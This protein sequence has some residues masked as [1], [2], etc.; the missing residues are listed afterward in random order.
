MTVGFPGKATSITDRVLSSVDVV[1]GS[2]SL[3]LLSSVIEQQGLQ[4]DVVRYPHLMRS[5][6]F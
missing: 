4:K 2:E 6:I 5:D 1:D 3:N